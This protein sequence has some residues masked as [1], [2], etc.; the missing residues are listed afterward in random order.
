MAKAYSYDFRQRVI[1]SVELD[2][3]KKYEACKLFNISRNTLNL[4]LQRRAATGDIKPKKRQPVLK[5][6]K[7]TDWDYFRQFVKANHDKTQAEMAEL[8][9]GEI[10]ARTISRALRKIKFTRKKNLWVSTKG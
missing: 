9:E 7:I 8:W 6:Q 4:W 5:N 3:L 2:G 1:Q 10:S